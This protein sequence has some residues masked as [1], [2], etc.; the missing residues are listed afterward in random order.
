MITL[1]D[2]NKVLGEQLI[3]WDGFVFPVLVSNVR[4]RFGGMDVECVPVGGSGKKW[5]SSDRLRNSD[6][7]HL[8][9][10]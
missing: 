7:S 9:A 8:A 1:E 3:S 4:P 5:V 6:G 10:S 2:M